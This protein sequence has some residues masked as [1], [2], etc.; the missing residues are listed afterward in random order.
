M[1]AWKKLST[2]SC[3]LYYLSVNF[4][5]F[6]LL[7]MYLNGALLFSSKMLKTKESSSFP[8]QLGTRADLTDGRWTETNGQLF[9]SQE[10]ED[11]RLLLCLA[12]H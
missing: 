10:S 1:L 2:G 8:F 6:S 5:F 12:I 11:W 4:Q 7:L 3:Y 9:F